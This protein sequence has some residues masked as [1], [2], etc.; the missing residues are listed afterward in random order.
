M[1][2]I[3]GLWVLQMVIITLNENLYSAETWFLCKR[4][5]FPIDNVTA[6]NYSGFP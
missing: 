5:Y 1:L 3:Y 6:G 4:E 2:I